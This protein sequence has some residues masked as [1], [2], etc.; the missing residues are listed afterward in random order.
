MIAFLLYIRTTSKEK[1]V[2]KYSKLFKSQEAK[3]HDILRLNDL[4]MKYEEAPIDL[5]EKTMK[6][7]LV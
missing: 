2:Q 6:R 4:L 7:K 3:K 1:K 5:I